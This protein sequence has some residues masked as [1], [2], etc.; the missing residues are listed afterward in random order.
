MHS[1][2]SEN[3][4]PHAMTVATSLIRHR[5]HVRYARP[6]TNETPN[7]LTFL[8]KSQSFFV[9]SFGRVVAPKAAIDVFLLVDF[10]RVE[11][12]WSRG[13]GTDGFPDLAFNVALF[14]RLVRS[15]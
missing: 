10:D 12:A 6:D 7:L 9:N 3:L 2:C 5:H 4:A 8:E 15:E 11:E 13:G 14:R 1:G